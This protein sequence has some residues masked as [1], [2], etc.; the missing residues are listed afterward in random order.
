MKKR[1]I[2]LLTC[3]ALLSGL[4]FVPEA[5]AG[6]TAFNITNQNCKVE[7]GKSFNIKLN[8]IKPSKVKWSSS[9]TSVATVSKTGT[10]SGVSKGKAVITGKYKGLQ[11][12]INVKV[13]KAYKKTIS[14]K[15]TTLGYVKDKVIKYNKKKL[16]GIKFDFTNDSSSPKYF[17]ELYTVE[18]YI[19]GVETYYDESDD[20]WINVKNGA[21][22]NPTFG[23][24]VKSG[25][26]IEF[27]IKKQGT[28]KVVFTKT[29][30]VP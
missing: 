14:Y 1:I 21:T 20:A 15:N 4:F 28:Y 30:V 5:D 26:E 13:T 16:W 18:A 29:Y 7:E 25:D 23:Y 6:S 19:N 24:Y 27:T 2:A 10:V 17:Y 3:I 22:I 12:K 8:G 11:L 9:K